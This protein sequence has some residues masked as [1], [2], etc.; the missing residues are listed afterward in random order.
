MAARGPKMADGVWKGVKS[1]PLCHL[2]SFYRSVSIPSGI[3]SG[4]K[5]SLPGPAFLLLGLAFLFPDLHYHFQERH[6]FTVTFPSRKMKNGRKSTSSAQSLKCPFRLGKFPFL[7]GPSR[8]CG[9]KLPQEGTFDLTL[10]NCQISALWMSRTLIRL[11]KILQTFALLM[12]AHFS[13][14]F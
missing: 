11:V 12:M 2:I 6:Y 1:L 7:S 13:K 14:N 10:T 5:I 8:F 9:F 3:N 4:P